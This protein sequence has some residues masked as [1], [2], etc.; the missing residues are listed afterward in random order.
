MARVHTPASAAAEL[1][2]IAASIVPRTV[3]ALTKASFDTQTRA[4]V[5]APVDTGNLQNSITI[6]PP[7]VNASGDVTVEGGPE[8]DYG[9]YVERGTSRMSAQPYVTPSVDEVTPGL[10]QALATLGLRP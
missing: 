6:D 7:T 2:A 5:R 1:S 3:T 10:D 9:E 4:R 8:A